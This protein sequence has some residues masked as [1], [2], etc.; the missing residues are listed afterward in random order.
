MI[1]KKFFVALSC[2]FCFYSF[3]LNNNELIDRL[4]DLEETIKEIHGK[5]ESAESCIKKNIARIEYLE[6]QIRKYEEE[7][8]KLEEKSKF[9]IEG[10]NVQS[11]KEIIDSCDDLIKQKKYKEAVALLEQFLLDYKEDIYRGQAYFFLGRAYELSLNKN[12]AVKAY[13]LCIKERPNGAK[14]HEALFFAANL[15]GMTGKKEAA[16]CLYK[17]LIDNYADKT[18]FVNKA[19]KALK[20]LKHNDK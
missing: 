2:C 7:K 14:A 16:K 18:D 8:I 17:R 11:S 3:A 10:K 1:Y 15:E 13:L 19:E 9:K 12:K 4:N 5:L 6:Q 20:K